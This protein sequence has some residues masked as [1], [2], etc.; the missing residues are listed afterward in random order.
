M[1]VSQQQL[2]KNTQGQIKMGHVD[3]PTH[4]DEWVWYLLL[5]PTKVTK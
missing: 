1:I 4:K 3:K 2:T 5:E